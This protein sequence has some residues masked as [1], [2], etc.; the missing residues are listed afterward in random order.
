MSLHI[1]VTSKSATAMAIQY[2]KNGYVI[3]VPTDTVYGIACDATNKSAI[4]NMYD[5]KCRNEN[6][7]LALCLSQVSDVKKIGYVSHLPQKLLDSLL[8]G[9]ITIILPCV[10]KT[11]DHSLSI[12]GKVGVRIPDCSFIRSL[13]SGLG[14]PLALTSANLSNEKNAIEIDDFKNIW[15]KLPVIFDGGKLKE[16]NNA[17][18]VVDLS[19]PGIFNIVRKGVSCESIVDVLTRFSLKNK[20]NEC[21][22]KQ[23]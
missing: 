22:I 8:P 12:E 11:L 18:T 16:D 10:D 7:P 5:I 20:H 9:P 15:Q 6:K 19:E 13:S 3:A 1:P 23:V 21:D 14:K 17:S 2:L 4:G